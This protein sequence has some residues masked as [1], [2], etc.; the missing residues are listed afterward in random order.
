MLQSVFGRRKK[1]EDFSGAT[2]FGGDISRCVETPLPSPPPLLDSPQHTLAPCCNR[3]CSQHS[4]R[5]G[6]ATHTRRVW[7]GGGR[8]ESGWRWFKALLPDGIDWACSA[9][10]DPLLW[11]R[12]HM[13][14]GTLSTHIRVT[15][16]ATVRRAAEVALH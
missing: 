10:L 15:F 7:E 6:C 16:N 2:L 8:F 4:G 1:E 9:A 13:S 12:C 3:G 11:T 5:S 14:T